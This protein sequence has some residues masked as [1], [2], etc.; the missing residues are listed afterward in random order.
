MISG[1]QISNN[2]KM[3]PELGTPPG[4]QYKTTYCVAGRVRRTEKLT[5]AIQAVPA[6]TS[7]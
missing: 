5:Y 4:R 1:Q 3:L 7:C 2:L 6:L